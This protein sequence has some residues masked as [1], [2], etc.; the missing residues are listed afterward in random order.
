MSSIK[1]SKG[2]NPHKKKTVSPS[3]LQ[4]K[5]SRKR[6]PDINETVGKAKKPKISS[7]HEPISPE[8]KCNAVKTETNKLSCDPENDSSVSV[9]DSKLGSLFKENKGPKTKKAQV[10]NNSVS[11]SSVTKKNACDTKK[12]KLLNKPKLSPS[13]TLNNPSKRKK[14]SVSC[15]SKSS[16]SV[17]LNDTAKTN[18]SKTPNGLESTP[19]DNKNTR[20]DTTKRKQSSEPKATRRQLPTIPSSNQRNQ[21]KKK[22]LK[23]LRVSEPVS[24]VNQEPTLLKD[25]DSKESAEFSSA[26]I[27]PEE[28]NPKYVFFSP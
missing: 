14:S 25:S 18:K 28:Y 3:H 26:N 17:N 16:H 1:K 13:A 6:R 8:V 27:K 15:E 23:T 11:S 2:T 7:E 19:T 12:A 4:R 5:D 22:K 24:P 9:N 10:A 20:A 21:T